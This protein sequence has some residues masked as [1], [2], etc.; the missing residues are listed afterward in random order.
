MSVNYEIRRVYV[1][2]QHNWI[3]EQ[4]GVKVGVKVQGRS[5]IMR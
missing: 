2:V 1:P 5:Y 4:K 3:N